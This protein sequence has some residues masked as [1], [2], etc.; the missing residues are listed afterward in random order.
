MS[1]MIIHAWQCVRMITLSE[2][3]YYNSKSVYLLQSTSYI[4]SR[5]VKVPDL[6][7]SVESVSTVVNPI[8]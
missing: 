5:L 6:E 3:R 2:C 7:N 4:L 1:Q 8:P